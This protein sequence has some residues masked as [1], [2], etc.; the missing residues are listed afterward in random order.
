[1]REEAARLKSSLF[2][3]LLVSLGLLG[4]AFALFFILW[5]TASHT[6]LSQIDTRILSL[7][8]FTL[9]QAALSTLLSLLLGTLLAWSLAHQPYFPGRVYLVALFSSSLVLPT[10][11]VVFGL[12]TRQ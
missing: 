10:L 1:M 8:R 9:Y 11:I 2:P 5:L 6:S 7:L 4:L 3:G 12:I